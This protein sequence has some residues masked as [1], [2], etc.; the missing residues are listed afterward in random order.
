MGD[1]QM[2]TEI[3]LTTALLAGPAP[4]AEAEAPRV[5]LGMVAG[6]LLASGEP[7]YE[8]P[9]EVEVKVP[10]EAAAPKQ[11]KL[12][13]PVR[14][15][16]HAKQTQANSLP[17]PTGRQ[18][19]A[20]SSG[21]DDILRRLERLE[22]ENRRLRQQLQ[23]QPTPSPQRRGTPA[24]MIS[25]WRVSL[26]PWNAEGFISGDPIRVFNIGNQRFNAKLG[27]KPVDRTDRS[28]PREVRRS[29]HTN[30][31]FIYKLEGWLQVKQAGQYQLGFEVNCGFSHPC[32]LSAKLGDQQ[33]FNERHKNFE[34]KV[35]F[36][37]RM[38]P[39]GN[40]RIEI[41]FNIARNQFMKFAPE[42]VSL[43]PQIRGPGEFNFR[44]FGP[45]ELLTEASAG[46]PGGPPR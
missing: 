7:R 13:A 10:K 19:L 14:S 26:Y 22:E 9:G 20:Q 30:E 38:L 21:N 41:M 45:E 34:N 33:M 35:L 25:G 6:L 40:Y 27:Q 36:Q 31:M 28:L 1:F 11:G 4:Q 3:A 46:I 39:V 2:L 32:N 18:L 24:Q 8:P 42:R 23:S 16:L 17:A 44:D 37:G 29:G 15:P 12:P 5:R 43:Y